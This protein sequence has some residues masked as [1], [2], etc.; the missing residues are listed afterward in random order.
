MHTLLKTKIGPFLVISSVLALWTLLAAQPVQAHEGTAG[1]L[2]APTCRN[3]PTASDFYGTPGNSEATAAVTSVALT[4]STTPKVGRGTAARG[5]YED[6]RYAKITIPQL[7]AG[8]LRVFDTRDTGVSDAILCRPGTDVTSRTSYSAHNAAESAAVAV[9]TAIA[10]NSISESSAKRALR[11]ARDALRTAARALTS[12]GNTGAAETANAA[13]NAADTAAATPAANAADASDEVTA[14]GPARDALRVARD[15]FHARFR[16]RTEVNPGDEE[17]ILVIAT[18]AAPT[19][20]IQFHGAIATTAA[21]QRQRTLNAGD[22]HTYGITVTAPGLL[23][24][25]TTG[26]T[27]TSGM[28]SGG[29][30]AEDDSSGSGNNFRIVA[31]VEGAA[32]GSETYTVTVEGQTATTT[33]PYTLDMDFKV[34]MQTDLPAI[35]DA[36]TVPPAPTWGTALAI[37]ADDGTPL[38]IQGSTDED[39]F[40]LTI[41]EGS[42]GFLTI[43][44]T[45]D[46]T[47]MTDAATTGT[48]Y[49]PTGELATD[50]N[51]GAD[52]SHFRIRAPVEE[53]MAYLVKVTGTTGV[54]QLRVTLDQAE[55]GALIPVPGTQNAPESSDCSSPAPGEICPPMSG[56]S[57]ETERFAFNI[58]ESGALYLHT[59]GAIDTVGTLYGPGGGQIA[60]DDNSGD[61]NNFRIA[62][63]V[64]AGLHLL[65]VRGKTRET[66]G[67]YSLVTNFVAGAGPTTPTTPGTD[68]DDV[69]S[70]QAE[71]TRL[72]NLLNECRA[73]VVTDARGNLG[74]PSGGGPRSGIG[75]IS[76]WVCEAEEVEV[77]IF[78]SRGVRIRTL[79][80]AYG[81]SRPDVPENS[82]CSNPNAGFGMTY[83]FNHL[84][85][86]DYTITAYADGDTQIGET[87]TFEVVHIVRSFP[88]SNNFLTL[89]DEVQARGECI[90]PDFP[91]TGERTWLRWEQSIQNFVIEDQG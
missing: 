3:L 49:G 53:E 2:R 11:A 13:A 51:S 88:D 68:D 89:D 12:A 25:E 63:N 8:E 50:T 32:D 29:V 76:G 82:S 80:V 74:N 78:N 26:S 7:A 81:T 86:G 19:W 6:L 35:S 30:T 62:V 27:D 42:S 69:A 46:M 36:V 21:T 77:R 90:V 60:T 34:A 5:G 20:D 31:P 28:L 43:E 41:D 66:T 44:A 17:Y 70:L 33:G 61:G 24:V 59:T 16:I 38:R 84:P 18:D 65:E 79:D 47:S 10:N 83:N 23:T 4:P 71:V 37:T 75:I 56:A 40:L 52:S 54:Y 72:Q 9:D 87:Q 85:E 73:P 58:M 67:V 64:N 14:L 15:A 57:L 22:Q 91:V 39:Y 48:F 55:G 1:A 45:D